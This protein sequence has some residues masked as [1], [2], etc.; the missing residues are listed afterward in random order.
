MENLGI[1]GVPTNRINLDDTVKAYHIP[2]WKKLS[3][4]QRMKY[5]R[6]ITLKAGRD[7]RIAT[8]A[9]KICKDANCEPREYRKQAAAILKWVQH[10]IYYVN[11]PGERLQDPIYTLRVGYGDCDDMA[12]LLAALYESLRLPW[13]FVL[14]G[15]SENGQIIRWIEG[16]PFRRAAYS[17]IY[18]VVGWPAFRPKVWAYAEPTLR[19]V[20]LGWDVVAATRQTNGAILPELAG[21]GESVKSYFSPEELDIRP[22]TIL[23]DVLKSLT[24]RR[25]AG[26]L[27]V[28]TVL[29]GIVAAVRSPPSGS[30]KSR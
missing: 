23:S 19:R 10:N 6:E 20:G 16:T 22:S 9:V 15:K 2:D 21:V 11:E 24:P 26:A 28:G 27:I 14:S 17:H 29:S 5:L 12:M 25:V 8:L 7:P 1:S 3:E 30:K 13:R 18:V 4:P